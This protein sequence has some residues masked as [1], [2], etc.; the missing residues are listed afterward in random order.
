MTNSRSLAA[1]AWRFWPAAAGVA[2][3]GMLVIAHGFERLA[4]L[5]PCALCLR[6]REVYWAALAVAAVGALF[7]MRRPGGP[8]ARAV[9]A[10]L[11]GVFLTGAVVAGYHAGVEWGFWEGPPGCSSSDL[12]NF[13]SDDLF[14]P[15]PPVACDVIPWSFAGL[16]MAGWNVLISIGLAACSFVAASRSLGGVLDDPAT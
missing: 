8:S 9:D 1:T 10:I 12:A 15:A 7:W 16:S 13:T 4:Q 6:Q 3:A 2:S 14:D 5:E 11:G